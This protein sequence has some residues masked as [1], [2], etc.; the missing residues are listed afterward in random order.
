MRNFRFWFP[1]VSQK[2]GVPIDSP[3]TY[4]KGLYVTVDK[5]APAFG[6]EQP[7]GKVS[8]KDV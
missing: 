8:H 2:R 6:L 1:S 5:S 4:N 3:V 7:K